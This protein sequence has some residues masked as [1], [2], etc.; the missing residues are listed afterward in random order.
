MLPI[1]VLAI[2]QILQSTPR[3]PNK[4]RGPLSWSQLY[5]FRHHREAKKLVPGGTSHH[6]Q[7]MMKKPVQIGKAAAPSPWLSEPWG[8]PCLRETQ[9]S[10]GKRRKRKG[11]RV[12]FPK[13]KGLPFKGLFLLLF[14]NCGKTHKTWNLPP[15]PLSSVR[16]RDINSICNTAQPT[17]LWIYS[18]FHH[19][20]KKLCTP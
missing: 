3:Y 5:V 7:T 20:K 10:I 6:S 13:T 17:P 4:A 19:P 1:I 11:Y 18:I 8:M 14:F 2:S 15:S 12:S 9:C 16:F